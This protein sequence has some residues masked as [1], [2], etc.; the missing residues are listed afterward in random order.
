MAFVKNLRWDAKQSQIHWENS[1][2]E[3]NK[4]SGGVEKKSQVVCKT[5][6]SRLGKFSGDVEQ[7]MLEVTPLSWAISLGSAPVNLWFP[8]MGQ[9]I[10][11]D[12]IQNNLGHHPY[13]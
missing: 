11:Y 4:I 5:I 12:I 1:Q 7:C 3:W 2:V 13:L 10:S 6:S 9:E 8:S